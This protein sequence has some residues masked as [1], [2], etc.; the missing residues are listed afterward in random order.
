MTVSCGKLLIG[1]IPEPSPVV[2]V[3]LINLLEC[4][5]SVSDSVG[6]SPFSWVLMHRLFDDPNL[7]SRII[8]NYGILLGYARI[9]TF[10]Y[11]FEL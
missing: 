3:F 10:V 8:T 2:G 11:L 9:S 5:S 6:G 7:L 1:I 4:P